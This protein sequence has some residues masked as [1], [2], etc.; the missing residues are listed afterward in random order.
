MF[1]A[2]FKY[3]ESFDCGYRIANFCN[4]NVRVGL[5]QQDK[6]GYFNVNKMLQVTRI[7]ETRAARVRRKLVS[8]PRKLAQKS[9]QNFLLLCL[10]VPRYTVIRTLSITRFGYLWNI[11]YLTNKKAW[12]G[13]IITMNLSAGHLQITKYAR[14]TLWFPSFYAFCSSIMM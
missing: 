12:V 7:R 10:G 5:D 3:D 9:S 11:L 4:K 1:I 2:Y 6:Q 13:E 8:V 14:F